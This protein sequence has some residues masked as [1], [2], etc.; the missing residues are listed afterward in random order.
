MRPSHAAPSLYLT[1]TR[2]I[3]IIGIGTD[4]VEIAR[5]ERMLSRHPDRSERKLFTPVE[6]EYCRRSQRPWESFA[7]RFAAKEALFKALGTGWTSGLSWK[8]VEIVRGDGA[9]SIRLYGESRSVAN[10]MGVVK[11]HLTLS[12]TDTMACAFVVLEGGP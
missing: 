3:V 8:E 5:I 2:G 4:L 9:P 7:A 6:I 10:E 11:S 12:H 1:N